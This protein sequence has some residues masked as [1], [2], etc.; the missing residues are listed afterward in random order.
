MYLLKQKHL[1]SLR[2]TMFISLGL[3]NKIIVDS[4]AFEILNFADI[5]N[6]WKRIKYVKIQMNADI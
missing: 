1:N 3:R 2:L 6:R 4:T 5:V